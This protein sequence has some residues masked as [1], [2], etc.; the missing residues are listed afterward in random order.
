MTLSDIKET[1][2]DAEYYRQKIGVKKKNPE[3]LRKLLDKLNKNL[4][5]MAKSSGMSVEEL[6]E[7][8]DP[9]NPC[10]F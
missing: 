5:E 6:I 9:S 7:V 3:E 1:K 4:E 10:P 8:L 2:K